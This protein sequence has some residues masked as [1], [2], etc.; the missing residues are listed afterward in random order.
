MPLVENPQ[1]LWNP[2][3]TS[4]LGEPHEAC[5]TAVHF[6]TVWVLVIHAI[7]YK[8]ASGRTGAFILAAL[9]AVVGAYITYVHPRQLT[10]KT[11]RGVFTI[12]GSALQIVIQSSMPTMVC[13]QGPSHT[14]AALVS[15]YPCVAG[16]RIL[17]GTCVK[18][19]PW[20]SSRMDTS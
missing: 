3:L 6:F 13:W 17:G 11:S 19:P 8:S 15:A 10:V 7:P 5:L 1:H 14:S 4:F 16:R 18:Q 20:T 12:R 9:V 2:L